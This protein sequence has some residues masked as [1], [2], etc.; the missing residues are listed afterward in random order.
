[1]GVLD[2][3]TYMKNRPKLIL[4]SHPLGMFNEM[5][6]HSVYVLGISDC[7]LAVCIGSSQYNYSIV[8]EHVNMYILK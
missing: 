3:M 2:S 1:M 6:M 7:M 4:S 8:T 5:M